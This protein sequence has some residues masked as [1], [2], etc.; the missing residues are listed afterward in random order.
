[1]GENAI[2]FAQ[3]EAFNDM[4]DDLFLD[5]AASTL[6]AAHGADTVRASRVLPLS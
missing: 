2:Q 1:M 5:V 4:A 3:S 6:P